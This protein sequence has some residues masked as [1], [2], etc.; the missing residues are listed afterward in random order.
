MVSH[1]LPDDDVVLEALK[2]WNYD[3][4]DRYN[5]VVAACWEFIIPGYGMDIPNL[6]SLSFPA[7]MEKAVDQMEKADTFEDLMEMVK[8]NIFEE[9][10]RLSGWCP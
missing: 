7:C 6:D 1:G 4:A 8:E 3:E 10:A 9:S 2:R 5:Y